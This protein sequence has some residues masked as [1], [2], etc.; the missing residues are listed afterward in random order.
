T[1]LPTASITPAPSLW[2]MTRGNGIPTTKVS[3]RFFTSPGLIPEAATRMRTS[4]GPGSGVA[5][6]PTTRTLAGGPC[7]SYQ[8]AFLTP[9]LHP[10]RKSAEL[11]MSLTDRLSRNARSVAIDQV[12]L[13]VGQADLDKHRNPV[14]EQMLRRVGQIESH[15]DHESSARCSGRFD[16]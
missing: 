12:G 14:P 2:G 11:A 13:V 3:W 15:R 10:P 9:P 1:P 6:S 5:I 4:P 7:R 16:P 8:A